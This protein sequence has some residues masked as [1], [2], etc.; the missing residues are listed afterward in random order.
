MK[1]DRIGGISF[2]IGLSR[3]SKTFK[4]TVGYTN[5]DIL[6]LSNRKKIV[7]TTSYLN[8]KLIEK[9]VKVIDPTHRYIKSKVV[10]KE[11]QNMSITEFDERRTLTWGDFLLELDNK[12]KALDIYPVKVRTP[13]DKRTELKHIK[14]LI[15]KGEEY[16]TQL[17]EPWLDLGYMTFKQYMSQMHRYIASQD[18]IID[19]IKNF[20]FNCHDYYKEML[21]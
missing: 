20:I 19:D 3:T 15:K 5:V 18:I 8:N 7:Y 14:N 10:K 2:G 21:K 1:I 16:Q 4:N 12:V 13:K 11:V 9:F 6:E 17:N